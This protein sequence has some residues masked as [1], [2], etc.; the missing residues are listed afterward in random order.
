MKYF[1]LIFSLMM[2]I[3][4][5]MGAADDLPRLGMTVLIAGLALGAHSIYTWRDNDNTPKLSLKDID[6]EKAALLSE[7][8]DKAVTD[9]KYLQSRQ[10]KLGDK[11]INSHLQRMQRTAKNLILHLEKHPERIPSAFKFIDYY[12]DRAVKIVQ[13]YQELEETELSTDKVRDLKERMKSTLASL[14]EAYNEQFE[15]V[16]NEQML[17]VEAELK[18]MEQQLDAE[19][20]K[21]PAI[22]I[23]LGE[24]DEDGNIN[25]NPHSKQLGRKH[26]PKYGRPVADLNNLTII[27]EGKRAMVIQRKLIQSALAIFF[28]ALGAHKFYQGKNLSG[29]FRIILSITFVMLPLMSFIGFCEGIRY[30]FMSIDDFY[31]QYVDDEHDK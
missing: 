19:G 2:I 25:Y 16:L 7:N 3:F 20:I 11:E 10:G 6:E 15:R 29:F 30:L 22:T 18:V 12:Q 4:G 26:K 8:F 9:Y 21:R 24:L 13:Q 23:D 27:P 1:K 17:S 31:L 14:D 28:G 5:G